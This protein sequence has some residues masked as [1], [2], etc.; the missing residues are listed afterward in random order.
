VIAPTG[1]SDGEMT[2]LAIKSAITINEPPMINDMGIKCRCRE[3]VIFRA[4]WGA[5]RSTKPITP[6]NAT[7]APV[8][9]EQR[10]SNLFLS[11]VVSTPTDLA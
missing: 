7:A 9:T 3:P 4:A 2:V 5:I 1:S 8:N 11:P 6:L 10:A